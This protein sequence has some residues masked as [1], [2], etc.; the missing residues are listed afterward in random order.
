MIAKYPH[1]FYNRKR[2]RKNGGHPPPPIDFQIRGLSQGELLEFPC[3]RSP[4]GE[5]FGSTTITARNPDRVV[6][7]LHGNKVTFMG[8]MSHAGNDHQGY[9]PREFVVSGFYF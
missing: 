8:L 5:V 1:I 4:K 3:V 6:F 2:M 7:M 9:H